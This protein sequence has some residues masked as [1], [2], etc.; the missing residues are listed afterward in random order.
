M[1]VGVEK[2]I[3]AAH[4]YCQVYI[5][6][7]G[8][9][10]LPKANDVVGAAMRAASSVKGNVAQLSVTKKLNRGARCLHKKDVT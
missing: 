3:A 7:R 1:I 10:P 6:R 8:D 4:G 9:K 5:I 2:F